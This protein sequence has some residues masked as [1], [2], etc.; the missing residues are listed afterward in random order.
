LHLDKFENKGKTSFKKLLKEGFKM[1][2]QTILPNARKENLVV[3][4]FPEEL[5]IYDLS[6]NKA[7]CLN[8]TAR[9]ALDECDGRKTLAQAKISLEAKLKTSIDEEILWLAVTQLKKNGLLDEKSSIP[10][11]PKVSRRDLMRIGAT[12]SVSLPLI[13]LVV[14]PTSVSAQSCL[15][16]LAACTPDGAACCPPQG[17]GVGFCAGNGGF[18]CNCGGGDD[19]CA[20]GVG[21]C[22]GFICDAACGNCCVPDPGG[23]NCLSPLSSC[24]VNGTACCPVPGQGIGICNTNDNVNRCNC[25]TGDDPCT[26]G[27]GCCPGFTCSP[28]CNCCIAN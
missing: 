5:L 13:S 7:F 20:L 3:M 9:L 18:F 15:A 4:E 22:P 17:G 10:Q 16:S 19:P 25:G 26:T 1:N 27:V 28:A 2:N 12:L 8:Q 14:A 24:T 11:I 23:Q 6:A 21:C